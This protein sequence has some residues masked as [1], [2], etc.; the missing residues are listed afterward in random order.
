MKD[1]V[2]DEDA[3]IVALERL[4]LPEALRLDVAKLSPPAPDTPAT[5]CVNPAPR[6]IV[7]E[8]KVTSPAV[9]ALVRMVVPP[10]PF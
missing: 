7:P 9:K 4:T 1:K 8:V 6:F 2:L 10:A 3:V 5:V